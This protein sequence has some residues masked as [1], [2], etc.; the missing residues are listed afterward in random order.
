MVTRNTWW[1]QFRIFALTRRV[2]GKTCLAVALHSQSKEYVLLK[3][4]IG[5]VYKKF[6][7][8]QGLSRCWSGA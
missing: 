8:E 2:L 1:V 7:I 3:V 6:K 5:S 4:L